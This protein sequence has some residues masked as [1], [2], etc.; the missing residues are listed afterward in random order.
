MHSHVPIQRDLFISTV[1]TMRTSVGLAYLELAR[2]LLVLVVGRV[3][4]ETRSM[5]AIEGTMSL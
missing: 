5:G 4:L 1:R 3:L 2:L